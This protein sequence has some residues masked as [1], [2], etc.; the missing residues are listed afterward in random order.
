MKRWIA[1]VLGP[2]GHG[3]ARLA[4]AFGLAVACWAVAGVGAGAGRAAT[5]LLAV[6]QPAPA[7]AP[8]AGG[9]PV[10]GGGAGSAGPVAHDPTYTALRAARPDG[11]VAE[12]H[13][14]AFDRDVF[15]FELESGTVHFL[16]PVGGRTIGAVFLGHGTLRLSPATPAERHQLALQLDA[17][18]DF[19]GLTDSFDELVLLFGDDTDRE[20]AAAAP[21]RSGA[22]DAHAKQVYERWLDRQRS[23]FHLNLQLRVLRDLLNHPGLTSGVFLALLAGKTLPPALVAVDPDGAGGLVG[24]LRLGAESSLLYVSEPHRGGIWYLSAPRGAVAGGAHRG[25]PRP[26]LARALHYWVATSVPRGTDLGGVTTIRF[27]VLAPGLRVLPI[28]LMPRL[29]IAEAAY[30]PAPS[31]P[32]PSADAEPEPAPDSIRAAAVV[33][34]EAKED[35]ADA[36]VVFPEPLAK[37]AEVLLRIAYHGDTVLQD[38]GDKNY[39]VGA[40]DSWYPSLGTFAEPAPFDLTYRVPAGN[41][42]VSV[43]RLVSTRALGQQSVSAW[44][45]DGPV[46]VAGFNYGQ[47]KELQQH[48]QDSGIDLQVF[49]NPGTPDIIRT[50]NAIL[51]SSGS[52]ELSGLG[53]DGEF[54]AAPQATLGHVNTAR[55]AEAAM[56]DGVNACRVFTTYFG[57]LA[58]KHVAITQQSQ[59]TFGQSW[60]SLIFMP[61]ISFLDST[62]R[63]RLGLTGAKDFVDKVGFHELSHQW[64]GHLVT[65]D[66]YRD[67]WLEEGFAE[68]SAALAVQHT[69]GWPAYLRFWRE[70]RKEIF[71]R[72][73]HSA[74]ASV[75][76]GPLTQG[77]R[78]ATERSPY[79]YQALVYEKG[80]YVLHMLRMLMWDA[81]DPAPDRRFIAMMHD[82]AATYAG[83]QASTADF[84]QVVERHMAPA[85][86]AAGDGKMDWFFRQWVYGAEVPRY[87]AEL[88]LESAGGEVHVKGKVTQEGVADDFRALV[89]IYLELDRGRFVRVAQLPM[90]GKATVPVDIAMKPPSK[91]RGVQINTRAEVLARD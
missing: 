60:P 48:D 72:P 41:Q 24:G 50:I 88:H 29:R 2:S 19:Q 43:G 37:G 91:P 58:E 55:L 34:E 82:Y 40:R 83:K 65:A 38:A 12:V 61:Y 30:G 75:D 89:P 57:P 4:A 31:P 35:G 56:A 18:G 16:A 45:T 8:A 27:S 68:F 22:P 59:F 28:Q 74:I 71:A 9:A 63:Q 53:V 51:E 20:I 54:N 76:A 13:G 46:R 79:A 21:V 80:A 52:R 77:F 5:P 62:Q 36:A 15:H 70:A 90:V 47:F 49:T 81:G 78:L 42:V 64:W 1:R 69:Q 73:P 66:S 25:A 32:P 26:Q 14:L 6:A 3:V 85:M 23:D 7:P 11:R 33:Q 44:K 39:V 17:G 84:Q 10:G 86:N 87:V 67:V